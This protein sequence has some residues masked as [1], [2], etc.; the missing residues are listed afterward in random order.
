MDKTVKMR[1]YSEP[2]K[3]DAVQGDL[4]EGKKKDLE[5]A[6]KDAQIEEEKSKALENLKTIVQLRENFKQEQAKTAEMS[7]R[8][9]ELE[10]KIK[11]LSASEASELAKKSAQLEEEKKRSLDH[12]R[13]IEQLR[14]SLKQAQEKSAGAIDKAAE[15]EAKSKELALIEAKLKDLNGVLGK[16]AS[17]A[18]AGKL[19]SGA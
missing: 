4:S 19:I 18:E 17:I 16:I 10:A 1:A 13:M 6:L 12:M 15:L 3:S 9:A 8:V 14:E 7:K 2:A 5:L 11:E